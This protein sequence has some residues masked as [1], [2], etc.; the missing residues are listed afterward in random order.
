M[1]PFVADEGPGAAAEEDAE[2]QEV[3]RLSMRE[4]ESA[5]RDAPP[6]GASL[7]A[8]PPPPAPEAALE[9]GE[10]DELQRAIQESLLTA[11]AAARSPGAGGS[12]SSSRPVLPSLDTAS[13]A[14]QGT[15]HDLSWY[16]QHS[17]SCAATATGAALPFGAS[18]APDDDISDLLLPRAAL[19]QKKPGD[20]CRP[21]ASWQREEEE[22]VSSFRSQL[23]PESL[24]FGYPPLPPAS[25]SS[26]SAASAASASSGRAGWCLRCGV[27][28]VSPLEPNAPERPQRGR[29]QG[30]EAGRE[31][32]RGRPASPVSPARLA[33]GEPQGAARSGSPFSEASTDNDEHWGAE[34]GEGRGRR[35]DLSIPNVRLCAT[36]HHQACVRSAVRRLLPR[37]FNE[38]AK[39]AP[40]TPELRQQLLSSLEPLERAEVERLVKRV[41]GLGPNR[42]IGAEDIARWFSH[43]FV[44][45]AEA[46]PG[47]SSPLVS[48]SPAAPPPEGRDVVCPWGLVQLHGGPCGLLASVQCF[49]LRALLFAPSR[50][51]RYSGLLSSTASAASGGGRGARLNAECANLFP[52]ALARGHALVEALAAI[53]FQAAEKSH[54]VVALAGLQDV[55]AASPLVGAARAGLED[56]GGERGR[57][58]EDPDEILTSCVEVFVKEFDNIQQVME[59]YWKFYKLLI[60][61]PAAVLSF[62]LSVVLTRGIQKVQADADTPDHPLLGLYGHCNQE[63]VNLLL[64]GAGTSNVWDGDKNLG[65]D[66]DTGAETV[67]GGVRKR[68]LVG[69]LTEME[70]LR[71]C[72]VGTRYKHPH[73][74]LWVLGSGNHYTTLFCRDILAA[75]LSATCQAE[76]EAQAA[77]KAIDQENNM[78]IL[79]Q[80]LRPLL[81]LLGQAHMEAEA[82]GA[83]GAADGVV[84][85]TEFLA[86]YTQLVSDVKAARGELGVEAPRRFAVYFYDGQ[87]PPGPSVRRYLVELQDVDFRHAQPDAFEIA[88][89]LW[90]RWPAAN[91]TEVP[92]LPLTVE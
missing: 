25:S 26:S 85:W 60:H 41:F 92:L 24:L 45:A 43:P 64:L 10:D 61:A 89:L 2:L 39:G 21:P 19:S 1:P 87:R 69:F 81:N 6:P 46:A 77:F 66:G 34:R 71:Y 90:T 3:L 4:F 30:R 58:R 78:Y 29:G 56:L 73:Y 12:S 42:A 88:R 91:V 27:S 31:G 23:L 55:E 83:M 68:P 20:R 74:P 84:L 75:A 50:A 40:D 36:C 14:S 53:L 15:L 52:S 48:P 44:F 62:L 13:A 86:W 17:P 57:R 49:V 33:S 76:M 32:D 11:A 5:R 18:L 59:F 82:R 38:D 8:L 47:S 37:N 9:L 65:A 67:L 22:E 7:H 16:G 54:Y 35:R 51:T 70:A 63:L 28:L 72:E 80:Q 79:S